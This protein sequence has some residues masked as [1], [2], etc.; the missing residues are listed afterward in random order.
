VLR[1]TAFGFTPHAT[2]AVQQCTADRCTNAFPVVFDA[3]GHA[4]FQYQLDV[5][6]ARDARG[7]E[8]RA[9]APPCAV[10]VSDG[11]RD[12][13]AVTVFREVAPPPRRVVLL[14]DDP[15]GRVRNGASVRLHVEG[16]APRERLR[17]VLCAAPATHGTRRCGTPGP[18]AAFAVDAAGTGATSLVVD[19]GPVGSSGARC[20][21]HSRCGIVVLSGGGRVPGPVVPIVFAAEPGARYEAGRLAGGLTLAVVLGLAAVVLVRRTDWRQPSEADTPELDEVRL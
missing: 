5:P 2:G 19:E 10:H 12:A 4:R 9:H 21:R 14:V 7:S 17:A 20:D 8:C 6:G 11:D 15:D 13:F 16:F 1:I 3:G 18:V